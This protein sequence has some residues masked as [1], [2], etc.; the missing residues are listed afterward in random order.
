MLD[1]GKAFTRSGRAFLSELY[2]IAFKLVLKT[3]I[4]CAPA[5][6]LDHRFLLPVIPLQ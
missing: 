5:A 3:N 2:F 1:G 4:K 6:Q